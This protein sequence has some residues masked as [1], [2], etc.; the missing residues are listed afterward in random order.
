LSEPTDGIGDVTGLAAPTVDATDIAALAKGG[1][2]NFL[3]FLLRLAARLPF[4]F[5]AGRLYGKENL[6][7]FASAV[8]A[9]EIAAQIAT[10]GQ[11]RGLAQLLQK[12]ERA[13]V[14]I[15][16]DGLFVSLGVSLALAGLLY[17]FP[18]IL[19]PSGD[20][21]PIERLLPLVIFPI[22]AGDIALAALAFRYDIATTVRARSLVEPWVLSIAA[23]GLWFV[24][25]DTGM[26]AAYFLSIT[27]A[28]VV[29][30]IA[31]VKSYGIPH[32]W[33]PHPLILGRQALTNLPIAGADLV[34][35]A[36]RK[37]DILLLGMLTNPSIV[38]VYWAAQQVASL[39]QKLK[40]SFE[41]ILSP[42]ITSS[43]KINDYAAIAKQV[44]QV[45]FWITAAQ[46]GIALAL[47]IPGA[48]VMG[49]VGAD[50]VGGTGALSLLL[51]AEVAA[52][53][54]V[55]AEAALIYVAPIRNLAISLVAIAVQIGLTIAAIDSFAL[56]A[57]PPLY[58]AAAAAGALFVALAFSSVT[59][60][61]LLR[62]I[63]QRP[64]N[65]WRWALVW[66]TVPAVLVGWVVVRLPEWAELIF[67][68]PA[69]L[70]AYG[71]VIWRRG[72]G[73]EDRVLFKR[74]KI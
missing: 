3:G 55:V 62:S 2:T 16:A 28:T 33:H 29:A 1:R 19:F 24:I 42:V 22:A 26:V 21:D 45:G 25:P 31:L 41:P 36:T 12:E 32:G 66:A 39:P 5:I 38:G 54:A 14:C 71:V 7:R 4:L 72:F 56:W 49:L 11:K 15:V 64:I 46:A 59:K 70:L 61:L 63:L 23:G 37:V 27:S 34:E 67:G 51:A 43:L 73:P 17:A 50:F 30:M 60:A 13:A 52:A 20:I 8:V 74:A 6:G 47:G 18:V 53:T 44:C 48:G 10:L 68:I 57:L 69:I 35:S 9:V 58:K 40:T 65:N